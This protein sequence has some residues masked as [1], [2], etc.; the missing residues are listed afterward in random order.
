MPSNYRPYY[1]R[2]VYP[3]AQGAG[4]AE[5]GLQVGSQI[6][7]LLGGFSEAIQGARQDAVANQ[8][9][10]AGPTGQDTTPVNLGTLPADS[11]APQD[12]TMP[13]AGVGPDVGSLMH[14]GGVAEM[15]LRQSALQDQIRQAQLADELAKTA[16]T[17]RYAA[18][19]K[20]VSPGVTATGGG[21]TSRWFSGGGQ[22]GQGG[23]AGG[24]QR[25]TKG[26]KPPPY[27]PGST[28]PENDEST[29]DPSQISADFDS[30]YGQ[31]GLYG[32]YLANLPNLKPDEQGNYTL[33]DKNGNTIASVPSSDAAIWQQR[34]NAARVKRGLTPLGP[35]G[36]GQNPTSNAPTGGP[37]NPVILQSK[38]HVRSLPFGTWVFDPSTNQTYQKQ[39]PPSS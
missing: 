35:L 33:T 4:D 31:K 11:A 3:R 24:G 22:D 32:K 17:G 6:G 13:D 25:T 20:G 1:P 16:G 9:M 10:N 39:R 21:N 15:K 29:D 7:K 18:R 38:L 14:T 27:Q 8:L 12:L 28:D 2:P 30:T 23:G 26:G 36:N 19:A 5:R 34:T 37:T